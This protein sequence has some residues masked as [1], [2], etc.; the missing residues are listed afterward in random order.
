M[1]AWQHR[2][3]GT[4]RSLRIKKHIAL[5]MD[6][7]VLSF[8]KLKHQELSLW[9]LLQPDPIRILRIVDGKHPSTRAVRLG[10]M[11]PSVFS[12]H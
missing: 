11:A 1:R 4:Q 2:A 9:Q 10:P 7:T 3:H 8:L 12:R 6:R 5:E